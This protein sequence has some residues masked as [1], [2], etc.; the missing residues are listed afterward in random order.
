MVVEQRHEGHGG[1]MIPAA[2]QGGPQKG[3]P[4]ASAS[5]LCLPL[6]NPYCPGQNSPEIHFI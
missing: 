2:V 4:Y 3:D 6:Y 5:T 1:A